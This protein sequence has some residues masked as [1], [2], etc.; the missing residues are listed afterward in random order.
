[1]Q[2]ISEPGNGVDTQGDSEVVQETPTATPDPRQFPPTLVAMDPPTLPAADGMAPPHRTTD[3]RG[4][5]D[6]PSVR[7]YPEPQRS[8]PGHPGIRRALRRV[9]LFWRTAS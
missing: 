3:N 6:L 4:P 1:M 7:P 2:R 8:V 9:F 5:M